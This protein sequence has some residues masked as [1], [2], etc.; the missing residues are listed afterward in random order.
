MDIFGG[1]GMAQWHNGTRKGLES[2][3]FIVNN[4]TPAGYIG[5]LKNITNDS[6]DKEV[7]RE[8]VNRQMDEDEGKFF[9]YG[10]GKAILA[11]AFDEDK[12]CAKL[13]LTPYSDK[14]AQKPIYA[15]FTKMYGKRGRFSGVF[16]GTEESITDWVSKNTIAV[17][18]LPGGGEPVN[19]KF[20]TK[21]LSRLIGCSADKA[22]VEEAIN[23][24]LGEETGEVRYWAYAGEAPEPFDAFDAKK[25]FAVV[26]ETPYQDKSGKKIYAYFS[27]KSARSFVW[28]GINFATEEGVRSWFSTHYLG[29]HIRFQ[30]HK[31]A[32]KFI[33]ELHD[34]LLPGETWSYKESEDRLYPRTKYQI[35]E[36]YLGQVF[37]KLYAD[38][39]DRDENKN[40]GKIAYS[41]NRR[42]GLFN[43]G[44]LT[45][46]ARDIYVTG[47]LGGAVHGGMYTELTSLK[48]MC[49]YDQSLLAAHGFAADEMRDK[50]PG[51]VD[52][53]DDKRVNAG[54]I[55]DSTIPVVF[56]EDKWNH[57]IMEN[58]ERFP[59]HYQR[60]I[61][62]GN[63][64][65]VADELEKEVRNAEKFAARNYT[66]IV[67][68]YRHKNRQCI[69]FLM[70]I[71]LDGE[72]DREPDFALVLNR[73]FS[74]YK[75]ETILDLSLAYNNAR[76]ISQP[77]NAWLKPE[78]MVESV[79]IDEE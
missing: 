65:K 68:Q 11:D 31:A 58:K 18:G 28:N 60:F 40:K 24:H 56:S 52:F 39:C 8:F 70:P 75:P 35:L 67:P 37:N 27:R 66:Y 19:Y 54:I 22:A 33:T 20:Q 21:E 30:T 43:T 32:D 13:V 48:I 72:Y 36:S 17:R 61:E 63:L 62:R 16:F 47:E 76:V 79:E 69:Q 5:N 73:E 1:E 3:G 9:E 64:Q 7:L 26:C 29:E 23:R 71:Y 38:E 50:M 74:Y 6:V 46:F 2:V 42:Y 49:G 14:H 44:L 57:I 59:E 78:N 12:T 25:T 41:R 15:Y 53:F 45:R 10:D 51:I 55:Y 77:R 4:K 34:S